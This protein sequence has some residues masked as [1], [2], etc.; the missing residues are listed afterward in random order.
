PVQGDAPGGAVAAEGLDGQARVGGA[1]GEGD[2]AGRGGAGFPGHGRSVHED[3]ERKPPR[4]QP[5]GRYG[6]GLLPASVPQTRSVSSLWR[7]LRCLPPRAVTCCDVTDGTGVTIRGQLDR[8]H[9]ARYWPARV[10]RGRF[11]W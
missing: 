8:G 2:A 5:M 11:A 7:G 9:L 6:G 3:H 10:P 4:P 1:F